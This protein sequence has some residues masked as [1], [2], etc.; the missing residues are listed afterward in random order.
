VHATTDSAFYTHHS[1]LLSA[2]EALGITTYL[3]YAAMAND[4]RPGMGF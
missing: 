4:M 2:E 1:M 3:G